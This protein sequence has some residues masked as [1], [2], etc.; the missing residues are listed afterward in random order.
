V[1]FMGDQQRYFGR[2]LMPVLPIV[3]LVGAWAAVEAAR[4]ASRTRGAPA[5]LTAVLTAV[6]MLAQ[7]AA[8]VVHNDT[9]LSRPDTRN[10]TRAWMVAHIPAGSRVVLEPLVPANWAM[11]IGRS[12]PYTPAGERWRRWP[13]SL[14]R[15]GSDGKLLPHGK[16][17]FVVEDQYERVLYPGL[18]RSYVRSGYCWVMIGSLQAGRAFAQPQDA[19]R[20][21]AYYAALARRGRL[22]FHISPFARG[23]H[24]VPFSFDW[25][26]DY[27]PR[28][29]RLPGPEISIYRL[30]GGRCRA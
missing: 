1:V 11:D 28:Q 15:L 16:R 5:W 8:A 22:M 30:H 3:A 27:Y 25:S 26:I 6:L 20:A 21:V 29:Y 23:A 18:V 17:R 7:S 24:A 12:L 10:L 9:V 14:T 13:T 2:W 4:W 19:P